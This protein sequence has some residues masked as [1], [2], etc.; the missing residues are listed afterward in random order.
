MSS[1]QTKH[2]YNICTMLGQRQ[3]R[4]ADVV[5]MFYKCF[6]FA[7]IGL[8]SIFCLDIFQDIL[9]FYPVLRQIYKIILIPLDIILFNSVV[10]FYYHDELQ[11]L[12]GIVMQ[13]A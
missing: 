7:G 2:L 9:P 1:Q 11:I 4:W 12:S 3:R 5:Q 10:L 13:K 8:I 6:V